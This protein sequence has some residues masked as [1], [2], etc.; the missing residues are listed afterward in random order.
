MIESLQE[1]IEKK[2]KEL[3]DER[4][5]LLFN[6]IEDNRIFHPP[7]ILGL[8]NEIRS[9]TRVI[10]ILKNEEGRFKKFN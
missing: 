3:D 5:Q 10:R 1:Q 7:V 2:I 8:V 4:A 6:L 9:L